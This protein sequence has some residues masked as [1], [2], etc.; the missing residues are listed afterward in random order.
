[1]KKDETNKFDYCPCF[2]EVKENKDSVKLGM[3]KC[4]KGAKWFL[5]IPGILIIT[6]FLLGYFL[7]P[8]TV[9]VLWLAITG[10]LLAFGITIYILMNLWIKGLLKKSGVRSS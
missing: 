6:A 9:R 10:T 3:M 8:A 7:D 2:E 4:M 5:L 1:M